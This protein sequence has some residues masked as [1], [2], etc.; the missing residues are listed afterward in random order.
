MGVAGIF[1]NQL[2]LYSFY[3]SSS[4]IQTFGYWI[5]VQT[6]NAKSKAEYPVIS[7][8]GIIFTVIIVPVTFAVRKALVKFGPREE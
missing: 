6:A 8:M 1:I 7:A 5:Y 4:P 3:G 2:N